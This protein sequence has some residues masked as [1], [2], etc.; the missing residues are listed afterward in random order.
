MTSIEDHYENAVKAFVGARDVYETLGLT[1]MIKLTEKNIQHVES[2]LPEKISR[3]KN[4]DK[5]MWWLAEDED[6]D[7]DEK[8]SKPPAS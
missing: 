3:P 2:L 1:R 5:S 6:E 7:E 4:D 8:P